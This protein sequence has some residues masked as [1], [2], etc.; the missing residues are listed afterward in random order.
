MVRLHSPISS[1]T[2]QQLCSRPLGAPTQAANAEYS[3]SRGGG[4]PC[5]SHVLVNKAH[6]KHAYHTYLAIYRLGQIRDASG[7]LP[8]VDVPLSPP[9]YSG[10]MC[11]RHAPPFPGSS[12]PHSSH[13]LMRTKGR[14]TDGC[15]VA[16]GRGEKEDRTLELTYNYELSTSAHSSDAKN[17]KRLFRTRGIARFAIV[18]I[19]N[20]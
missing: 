15:Y 13:T 12:S 7:K 1:W 18:H 19:H 2:F 4:G 5:Y 17:K 8:E 3:F 10:P 20:T 6:T 16:W 14:K 11:H 9:A